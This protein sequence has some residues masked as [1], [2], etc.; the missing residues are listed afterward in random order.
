[1]ELIYA[2]AHTSENFDTFRDVQTYNGWGKTLED[3]QFSKLSRF[4]PEGESA[5]LPKGTEVKFKLQSYNHT[6]DKDNCSVLTLQHIDG[7]D[8]YEFKTSLNLKLEN[9]A[10]IWGLHRYA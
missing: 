5:T 3:L 9:A 4:K 8:A 2:T 7:E 10:Y 6:R 1:M